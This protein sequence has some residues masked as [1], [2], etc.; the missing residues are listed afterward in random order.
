MLPPEFQS[1]QRVVNSGGS[2]QRE[3][4]VGTKRADLVVT[5]GGRKDVIELELASASKAL[6]RGLAQVA[7]YAKCLGRDAGYLIL[8]DTSGDTPWEDRGGVE[9]VESDGVTVVVVRA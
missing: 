2:I 5:F 9:E 3:F 6:E 8:F 1:I 4:A 7:S